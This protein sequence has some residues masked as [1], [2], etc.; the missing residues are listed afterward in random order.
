MSRIFFNIKVCG[1]EDHR[2]GFLDGNLF[3]N[4]LGYFRNYEEDGVANIGDYHEATISLLQPGQFTMTIN[5]YT[6]PA[7]D[8]AGPS[9]VQYNGHNTL[10]LLCLYAIHER[11]YSFNS[12]EDFER[13]VA[14][15][16]MK[17][18]VDG[19]G[20]YAAVVVNTKE[21][22][23]RVA[24]A[25]KK[26][27]FKAMG[28]L[29]DYYNPE[30]FH[31]TFEENRAIFKKRDVYSHQKEYRFALDRGVEEESSYTLKVG[32]LRDICFG[33]RTSEV[34]DLIRSYLYQ[35]KDQGVFG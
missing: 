19:L 25:I 9:V 11:G 2:E 34:N 8:F 7:E 16:M 26:E 4:T 29:V 24:Q 35:M 22:Q 28:S 30:T 10:N 3:M 23:K 17:P 6:I 31:G 13:F 15:Q 1:K 5:D 21:F 18:E 14:D 12:D 27:N 32:S 33:C 20:E